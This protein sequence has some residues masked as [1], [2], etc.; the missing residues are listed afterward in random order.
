M[1][2]NM[3]TGMY[4]LRQF[5]SNAD[6]V[7]VI[8]IVNTL[9]KLPFV[10]LIVF[11]AFYALCADDFR[12]PYGVA[13]LVILIIN[14]F[15]GLAIILSAISFLSG[16]LLKIRING[17]SAKDIEEFRRRSCRLLRLSRKLEKRG[18]GYIAADRGTVALCYMNGEK[19]Q[20]F[21]LN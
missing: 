4:K 20:L 1:G 9:A 8:K 16:L 21:Q 15:L 19:I 18:V 10:G 5:M 6:I 2:E 7:K 12:F 13:L 11:A 17:I 3:Q 14:D